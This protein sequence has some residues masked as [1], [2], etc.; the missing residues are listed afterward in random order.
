[1]LALRLL[2]ALDEGRPPAECLC[3]TFTNRAARELR[4]RVAALAGGLPPIAV[5]TFHGFCASFLREEAEAAGLSQDVTIMDDG[6]SEELL[7]L[8]ARRLDLDGALGGEARG[9]YFR[10]GRRLSALPGGGLPTDRVPAAAL[11]GL[12]GP[13]RRLLGAYLEELGRRGALDFPLLVY[14]TRAL[15]G[16]DPVLRDRWARRWSWLQVD[17][18]QDTH[19]SEWDV[20]LPLVE[21][22]G[23]LAFFGDL[24]QTIYGWRGSRPGELLKA[25]AACCGEPLRLNL[26]L[27][28]RGTRRILELADHVA[29]GLPERS[30]RLQPAATL[31]GG[32]PLRWLLGEHPEDEAQRV[33][34]DLLQRF[35]VDPAARASSAV[36][37]R[38]AA[39]GARMRRAL[40]AAGLPTADENDLRLGRRPEIKALL[41]PLRLA[42]NLDDR[43]AFGRWLRF[44]GS[45]PE[46]RAALD[47]IALHG[48]DCRLE[49]SDL[50]HPRTLASGDP[51]HDLL[52]AVDE[53]FVIV[54]DFETTGLRP[55]RDEIIEIA[56]QRWSRDLQ[57]DEFHRLLRPTVAP[58]AS[59][60][61]HGLDAERLQRE[62]QEPA[63]ALRD[64]LDYLGDALIIGHNIDFD[65]GML[66]AQAR[67]LD[68]PL[69]PL[70]ACDTLRLARRV[71]GR[72]SLRLGDL[73]ERLALPSAPT[74]RA[75]DDV[76]TTAELL[77]R[78]LPEIAAGAE[79]RRDL[80]QR[81]GASFR[82]LAGRVERLRQLS[83]TLRPWE[84]LREVLG[85]P[86]YAERL[87]GTGTPPDS[88]RRLISWLRRLDEDELGSLP[89]ALA[90]REA[91]AL[92]ALAQ[93]VD[94]LEGEAVPILTIHAAKGMEFD[95]VWL[96][97][98]RQGVLPD[99]RNDR[100]ERLDEE[101]R[102]CYVAVTRARCSLTLS[103]SRQDER[104]RVA[105][106]SEFLREVAQP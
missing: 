10:W 26:S 29:R 4:Q 42:A 83:Q 13:Q 78:L 51:F 24:D 49:A 25:F 40:T 48:A 72:G 73:R 90:L 39:I 61:V 5:Q 22:H 105:G 94:L 45:S 14:R 33:A 52:S 31:P 38:S 44:A 28:Q 103:A 104:G 80:I 30:T 1:V 56:C 17:E 95:H 18:I 47:A 106:F 74:H 101:R 102:V 60:A 91:L 85:W 6:D 8:L 11:Q 70:N 36:L 99:F 98:A 2:R 9:F 50:L 57:L 58:G 84:L 96:A 59:T 100:G 16:A 3:L 77:R 23:N 12:D 46:L 67:R 68:L 71:L 65:L 37:V 35:S 97:G 20:L 69:P 86:G 92:C 19:L 79:D 7:A 87:G 89:P 27:N 88:V 43:Q 21:T 82:P 34:K 41:A 81:H 93:P 63:E 55:E 54:L 64:L 75:M 53:R 32:E 62:G 15:L 76:Q 66:A